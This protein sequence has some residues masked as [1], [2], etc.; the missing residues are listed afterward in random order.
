MISLW[1]VLLL[2]A[3]AVA[4]T[5]WWD[6]LSALP[7]A[8][9]KLRGGDV[10]LVFAHPDDEAM[11]FA[12]LL[13]Y[14][15]RVNV[16][17][18]LLC[19][20]TGNYNGLGAVREKELLRSAA[21]YGIRAEQV[22]TLNEPD[23]QDGMRAA[24]PKDVV[25]RHVREMLFAVAPT[26][27]CVVTFD[28]HGVSGHPNHI[29]TFRGVELLQQQLRNNSGEG[30][31]GSSRNILF[32]K[33]TTHSVL[34]KYSAVLSLAVSRVME[35]LRSRGQSEGSRRFEDDRKEDPSTPSSRVF[36]IRIRPGRVLSSL[37]GMQCHPSQLV[38]FRYLFVW[39][40]SYTFVNEL[41][42][43]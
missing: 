39:F 25:A 6:R 19:L 40:S 15:R 2:A 41:Q 11:F 30:G 37:K 26:V 29:D 42:P 7:V 28:S 17:V 8:F 24:W 9:N 36:Y 32:L 21:Y 12:P 5:A 16:R 4:F 34:R 27:R 1:T 20:S 31:G 23:L 33:L 38:W 43:I 13:E 10:L 18:H 22:R 3:V 35:S 14:L